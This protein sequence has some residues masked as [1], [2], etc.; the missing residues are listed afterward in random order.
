[1]PNTGSSAVETMESRQIVSTRVFAVPRKR[2]WEAVT[3]PWQVGQW[4]GPKGF[5]TTMTE[6]D[7]RPGGYWRL[8]MR[9]PDGTKYPNEMV[10]TEVVPMERIS[11]RLKGGREGGPPVEFVQTMTFTEEEGGTRFTITATFETAEQREENVRTY[12]SIEGAQQMF[13]R[14]ERHLAPIEEPEEGRHVLKVT[15]VFQAPRELVWRA[16]TDAEMAKQWGGPKQ[17]PVAHLEQD[18]RVGGRW[19][20]CLR[21]TPPGADGPVEVWQGGRF[22]EVR[23]PEL[24]VFSYAWEKRASVGLAEDGDPHETTVTV[25]LEEHD[26]KTT[27]YFRQEFFPTAAERDGHKGGWSSSFDRLEEF[28]RAQG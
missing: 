28:V 2:L 8:V 20:K 15:R 4:W 22:L 10:F 21:G 9:G 12:R 16:W 5:T 7:L 11:V 24:L 26:G 3:D 13:E 18:V 6:M 27:M 19:R 23:P 25:Q 17:F 1:M 14:L